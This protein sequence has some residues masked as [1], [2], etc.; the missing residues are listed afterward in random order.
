[1]S[2]GTATVSQVASNWLGW[3]SASNSIWATFLPIAGTNGFLKAET[4]TLATVLARGNSSITQPTIRLGGDNGMAYV[5]GQLELYDAGLLAYVTIAFDTGTL[6]LQSA[7]KN[8]ISMQASNITALGQFIGPGSGL[9]GTGSTF[10]AGNALAG[11]PTTWPQYL[12]T[13]ATLL[14]VVQGGSNQTITAGGTLTIAASS[15]GGGGLTTIA[16]SHA[17]FSIPS[18]STASRVGTDYHLTQTVT[19]DTLKKAGYAMY[20]S[21]TTNQ[22]FCDSA[23][24]SGTATGLYQVLLEPVAGTTNWPTSWTYTNLITV[25][26]AWSTAVHIPNGLYDIQVTAQHPTGTTNLLRNLLRRQ[27]Q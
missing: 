2:V 10:T 22:W 16:L 14:T 19:N 8:D 1:M 7:G 6:K 4:D 3:G 26:G 25:G 12:A 11:W 23:A 13:N 17:A 9:T 20:D 21:W 24:Y 5:G 15:G 18:G 27:A